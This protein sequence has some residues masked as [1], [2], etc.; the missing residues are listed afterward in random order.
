ML[1]VGFAV[2]SL[3]GCL[4]HHDHP[5]TSFSSAEDHRFF[6]AA[7]QTFDS[8]LAGR[9]T[10]EASRASPLWSTPDSRLRLILTS[11]PGRFAGDARAGELEFHDTTVVE[12]VASLKARDRERCAV[13]GGA[14]LFTDAC[15]ANL[16]DELWITLEPLGFGRGARMFE[17]DVDFRFTL[18]STEALSE[19]TLL[20]KYR[21]P[22]A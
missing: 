4:T 10:Y 8:V 1:L 3:D 20:L 16:L 14:R 6:R 7:L 12:A 13:L 15:R 17:G 11:T 22:V 2:M 19:N 18:S 21:R 5:G 9:K